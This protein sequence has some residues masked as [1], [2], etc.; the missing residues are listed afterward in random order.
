MPGTE[1]DVPIYTFNL[2][3]YRVGNLPSGAHRRYAF[4]GLS[5]Q[6][7]SAIELLE[8]GRDLDWDASLR[9]AWP[10]ARRGQHR[11]GLTAGP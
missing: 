5:D 6:G 3:G 11:A 9:A 4:G 8:R 7:F 1:F 10:C 2:T